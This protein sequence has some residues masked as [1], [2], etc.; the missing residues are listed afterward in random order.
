MF[1][2]L[3]LTGCNGQEHDGTQTSITGK[4]PD[5]QAVL[6]LNPDADILQWDGAIYQANIDWVNKLG[7]SEVPRLGMQKGILPILQPLKTGRQINDQLGQRFS[8]L[9]REVTY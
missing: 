7:L 8:Q 5:A 4:L 6:S 9:K 2:L 3:S 1:I